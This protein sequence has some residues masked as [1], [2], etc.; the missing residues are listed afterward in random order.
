MNLRKDMKESGEYYSK[1]L[2]PFQDGILRIVS[3]LNLPFYLTGGTAL[4]RYYF[5][6][7]YSDDLDLF[8]NADP[9]Y[10]NYIKLLIAALEVK[11]NEGALTLHKNKLITL[12]DYTQVILS[13][14]EATLKI[15]LV[16]D[17]GAHF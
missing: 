6:H 7:R 12:E 1:N 2:Y 11:E 9:N 4:S 3:E 10:K 13:K 15:D 17:I 16:N 8:V 5:Q 14:N